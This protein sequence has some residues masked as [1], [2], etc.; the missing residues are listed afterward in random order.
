[1][2]IF[3]ISSIYLINGGINLKSISAIFLAI[4]ILKVLL[5]NKKKF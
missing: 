3:S 2:V 5:L 4:E 1:M